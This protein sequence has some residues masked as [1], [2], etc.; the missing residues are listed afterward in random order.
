M[1]LFFERL[2][3]S[4]RLQFVAAPDDCFLR[5]YLQ[6]WVRCARFLHLSLS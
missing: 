6:S 1:L 2:C 4:M 5:A 3:A